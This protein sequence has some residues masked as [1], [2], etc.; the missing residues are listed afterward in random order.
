MKQCALLFAAL[1]L[2]G[3]ACAD[4]TESLGDG[5]FFRDEGSTVRDILSRRT[6]G[7]EVPATVTA[8]VYDDRFILAQQRPDLPPDPLYKATYNYPDP[9]RDYFWIIDKR[10]DSQ[11]GPLSFRE[12]EAARDRYG[13]PDNLVLAW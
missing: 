3:S 5:Y 9:D 12:Y 7:G 6:A 4:R 13:V 10:D 11:T 2:L 1:S 8:Y